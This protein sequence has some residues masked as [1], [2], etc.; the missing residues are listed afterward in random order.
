[1]SRG[2]VRRGWLRLGRGTVI[3]ELL[4]NT[5][6]PVRRRSS[7]S[8]WSV[9]SQR[10]DRRRRRS[11]RGRRYLRRMRL[12]STKVL[13][14]HLIIRIYIRE[15]NQGRSRGKV[16]LRREG[17]HVNWLGRCTRKYPLI[18]LSCVADKLLL[19]VRIPEQP[20]LILCRV[21]NKDTL[22]SM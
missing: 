7:S 21:T 20:A 5:L 6:L 16:G 13:Y 14:S 1:M 17:S 8:L 19:S 18:K 9:L 10:W 15:M 12:R 3:P 11:S 4:S 2:N 22:L